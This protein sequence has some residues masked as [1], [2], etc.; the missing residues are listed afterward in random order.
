MHHAVGISSAPLV[1]CILG[2][3]VGAAVACLLLWRQERSARHAV[4][5]STTA[6][7]RSEA[8]LQAL[9]R[10][11][12][13]I[14]AIFDREGRCVFAS[15]SA[16]RG[17]GRSVEQLLAAPP[18][19]FVH[20]DDRAAV[21]GTF[22]AIC[23]RPGSV[24][25]PFEFQVVHDD[26]TWHT[27]EAV[28]T[29]LTDDPAVD[30]IVMNARDVTE[31]RWAEAELREAQERFRSAFEHAP[32]GMALAGIDGEL[33]RV[34]RALARMLGRAEDQ[35]LGVSIL[36]L[37][38]PDDQPTIRAHLDRLV[39]GEI[40]SYQVE[41]RY[42]HTD[43]R[44]VWTALSASLVR[45]SIGTP[46]YVVNQIEDVTAR[47]RDGERLAHQAIHDP[48]TSLP[49]RLLFV[50]RLR[51]ALARDTA[52]NTAV[53]FLDLD[54][55]KVI[56][57]SL[58]H[59]AGDRLLVT[60]SDRL[61]NAVRPNDTVAR[62]GG[63]E[64]T[65]LCCNVPDERVAA[66]IAERIASA[67]ARPVQLAEGEVYVTI[68][69]GIALSG[70]DMET[71]E[72]LLRNADAAMYSAKENGR[73]RFELYAADSR[74]HAVTKLRTGNDLRRAL[75]QEELRVFYQPIF[76]LD[77]NR[78]SG[79]EALVRW[80]HPERGLVAPNDFI[81]LAEETGLV[82]PIGSWV[83][84]EAC[85]QGAEW[86]AGGAPVSISI[87]LSPRQLAE[88]T[89]PRIVAG[90]LDRT[91]VDPNR[92]WLEITESTLMR[93]AESAVSMLHH[94][95]DLGVHLAVDD[96][97]TGYSSMTYLK[98]FPV[99][100]L[101]VDQSFVDGLASEPEATAI[102]TAVVSLAHALGMGAVA[103][104][105]ATPQQLHAL[106]ALGCEFAQGFLFG[107]PA[108]ADRFGLRA[109]DPRAIEPASAPA[110]TAPLRTLAPTPAAR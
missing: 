71:P 70:G 87:N 58:G 54:H 8:R 73:A 23:H 69:I 40:P 103:E 89:L 9:V 20:T 48:L 14:I 77:T 41:Q 44:E 45:D 108:P 92:V 36:E 88:S 50:D 78:I 105:V 60:I 57:D 107:R 13:D 26:G 1:A 81:P 4:S 67:V 31:R 93:D 110:L 96:F 32:I 62:F 30:G 17:L 104:G 100:S 39:T 80:E 6:V 53:L 5:D 18:F 91:G 7:R 72:T 76:E 15:P 12:H 24:S 10:N 101:K 95:R 59:S 3:A 65:V 106:R 47:R 86:Q 64:F 66:E 43:G 27:L 38:H 74:Y 19:D 75:E 2:A 28:G 84:E 90:A 61:R 85:R 11:S 63:D 29:N 98:R 94:L 51:R 16:E 102:C 83:L 109:A 56:N 49:N 97:G 34:N 46:M 37:T 21:L 82:V 52:G 33:F 25:P 42:L 79:F 35:L 68:S 55:F 22:T 99:D